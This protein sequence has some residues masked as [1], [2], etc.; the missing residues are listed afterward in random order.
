MRW[1]IRSFAVLV[2]LA[3]LGVA[4]LFLIPAER[5][6]GLATDRFEAATGRALSIQGSVRPSL[7]PVLGA[8]VEGISVAN[9]EWSSAGPMFTADVVDLGVDLAAL[10]NGDLVIRRFEARAPQILLERGADGRGNWE[11]GAGAS[12]AEGGGALALPILERAE[13]SDAQLRFVD[14]G[15]GTEVS[16]SALDLTVA[17]PMGG[18]GAG[19]VTA[20]GQIGGQ[21]FTLTAAL[22][23]PD[24]FLGGA[25]SAVSAQLRAGDARVEFQGRASLSPLAT[26][27]QLSLN[28]PG[29]APLLAL[30]GQ[31]GEP[32]PA[33][34]RPLT[35]E[36][37]V[38]VAPEG[39][40]HLRQGV[41]ALG[42]NRL[43][44]ALDLALDGDR[45]NLTG[46]ISAQGLDLRPYLAGGAPSGPG[47]PTSRIDASALG[48]LDARL[49]LSAGAV[50]TGFADLDG[51][52]GTLSI[53]R[54]RAVLDI[55]EAR[56]HGGRLA[57][58]V[59]ANN[60][61]GLSVGGNLRAEG[62]SLLG[63]LR[64]LAGLERLTG[65]ATANL[66]FLGV[67]QSVDAIM[68]SLSGEGQLR[69][70]DGAIIGLDLAGMLR[71]LDMSYMGEGNRT[72][73]DTITG[74]FTIAGGVLSNED[75]RVNAPLVS[76]DGRGRVNL[77]AQTLD[78]RL[79][80][81]GLRDGAGNAIRVP[82][83]ITGPWS[84]P[85][86]RL[87]LEGMAE[88]RLREEAARLEA[89]AREEIQRLEAEARTRAEDEAARALGVERQEG[90][91]LEDAARERLEDELQ[92]GLLRLLNPGE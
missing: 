52:R 73:F 80:P 74:S 8:R 58:E 62:L 14:H 17:L 59:V 12:G 4:A 27:G 90:Q 5:L 29:L 20:T 70:S 40:V 11:F 7:F 36:G 38:T 61:S 24:A 46:D 91:T 13:I 3:V 88:E 51:F 72:V 48:L 44:L 25:V 10:W 45:P 83:L 18:A 57:G 92:R 33:A 69:F 56:L 87:D 1:I 15:A 21:A 85:R 22:G 53:E 71:T 77:G 19:D 63:L 89:R 30:T 34:A 75:L 32:L 39:S 41:L 2:S 86:M 42:A 66:R 47:W 54:A 60:R 65:T 43:G 9:A 26:D 50:Q 23:S 78:Y 37:Q 49:G 76:V 68:R 28:A 79:I 6:A 81:E 82:L 31:Q 16:L 84:G 35:L 67:G 64:Q 55:G